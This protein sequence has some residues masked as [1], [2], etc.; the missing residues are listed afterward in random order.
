M[1]EASLGCERLNP[2]ILKSRES[3]RKK[4]KR[5]NPIILTFIFGKTLSA[6]NTQICTITHHTGQ[7]GKCL[8]N[9][10]NCV[11]THPHSSL[12]SEAA[13]VKYVTQ[14]DYIMDL[15]NSSTGNS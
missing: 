2:R 1:A 13:S 15:E 12:E 3:E 10:R 11:N 5:E 9:R 6:S 4:S 8:F 7:L 14:L